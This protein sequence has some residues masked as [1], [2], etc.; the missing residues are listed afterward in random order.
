[1]R[2]AGGRYYV[3]AAYI[4]HTR[5]PTY[6]SSVRAAAAAM[7]LADTLRATFGFSVVVQIVAL[8]LTIL[9]LQKDGASELLTLI[10]TAE[11]ITSGVQ[12]V[13]YLTV[14]GFYYVRKVDWVL[15]ISLRYIDW[16]ITTPLMIV[17]LNLLI[18][19]WKDQCTAL[20]DVWNSGSWVGGN[21]FALV[22]NLV[23]LLCGVL[24]ETEKIEPE[25]ELTVLNWGFVPLILAFIPSVVIVVTNYTFHAA[26]V[27]VVTVGIWSCYGGVSQA[28]HDQR[29]RK[30]AA[31]NILDV[32]S[33]NVFAI[34]V[35]A[36]VLADDLN[37]GAR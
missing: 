7:E 16:G 35:S 1:M 34:A 29:D 37:C 3:A 31:F 14:I 27:V 12:L 15:T 17:T 30:A 36:I 32:I 24:V 26:A 8:V 21:V 11:L 19:Y 9:A 5:P 20:D 25:Y 23:M 22:A 2:V 33:K 6:Q 4:S 10:L 13:W 18:L 28:Y